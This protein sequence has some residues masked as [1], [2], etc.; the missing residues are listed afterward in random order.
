[1]KNFGRVLRVTLRYRMTLVA[2]VICAVAVAVLWGGSISA[3]YPV[4]EVVLRGQT[5]SQWVDDRVEYGTR[6]KTEFEQ[7][8]AELERML[9]LRSPAELRRRLNAR[10]AELERIRPAER[11]HVTQ[12]EIAKVQ[13]W[14]QIASDRDLRKTLEKQQVDAWKRV[15]AEEAE[16]ARVRWVQPYIHAYAPNDAFQTLVYIFVF[17]LGITLLKD[18]FLIGSAIC[19]A[20]LAQLTSL[21][22]RKDLYD[23]ILATDLASIGQRSRGDV[24][25]RMTG[26]VGAVSR[27]VST[28]FG[29]ALREPLKMIACL[30]GAAMVSWRLLLLSLVVVPVAAYLVSRLAKSLKRANRRAMEKMALVYNRLTETLGGIKVVKA[31]TMEGYE[32]Q[33]FDTTARQ[34][35]QQAMK[36]AR[37]DALVSPL[38][39]VMGMIM[40]TLAVLVGAYLSLSHE[41]DLFGIKISDRRL[42]TGACMLFYGLLAGVSEPA[43]KLSGVF[44][45]VQGESA[46]SDRIFAVMDRA[47]SV[48]DPKSPRRLPRHTRDLAFMGVHFSYDAEQPVLQDINLQVSFGETLAIVGANGCG[49]STLVNL[50]PRFFDPS[51]GSVKLDG[52]DLREVRQHDLRRQIGLVTQETLLFDDTIFDNIRYGSPNASRDQ[53]IA[54]ARRAHAHK[55]IETKLARG[56]KTMVGPGGQ[57][58]SGGQRQRIALARAILRDPAILI[59]DEA[60]SQIDLESEQLIHQALEQFIRDRTAV[61]ITHRLTTLALADR[62]LVMDQGR[63][64]DIGSHKQLLARCELYRRLHQVELKQT[65]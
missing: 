55:F 14:L 10:Y 8:G 11:D 15:D 2:A 36:I 64:L 20:R 21:Q 51:S 12:N 7:K 38:N 16:L 57:R 58:L 43:R 3:V 27:G 37:Y 29:R 59:L 31:F 23:H 47:P 54:A 65:A 61:V 48:A 32:R 24:M 62:I 5:M 22:L 40:I 34:H 19:V 13:G 17:L 41:T 44:A 42:S 53:V 49:K 39:E 33:R 30:V 45:G 28:L 1:M 52:I 25:S 60:T 50:I 46:A 26:D 18:V 35:Y 4:V 63:I 6:T 56:Y 9:A